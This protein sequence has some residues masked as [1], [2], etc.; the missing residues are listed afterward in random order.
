MILSKRTLHQNYPTTE[1]PRVRLVMTEISKKL[2]SRTEVSPG[3]PWGRHILFLGTG[4]LLF[5]SIVWFGGYQGIERLAHLR[6]GPLCLAF[7]ATIGVTVTSSIR[8]GM[9]INS[10]A[11]KRPA[12]WF[13]YYYY[14]IISR[15]LGHIVPKDIAD[16]GFRT[17]VASKFNGLGLS[18]AG[19][20]VIL[21]RVFDLLFTLLTLT[22]AVPYWLG[23]FT[24]VMGI[25]L[26]IV[27][28]SLSAVLLLLNQKFITCR[29][30]MLLNKGLR[31]LYRLPV[32][33]KREKVSVA[34][35]GLKKNVILRMYL[36]TAV[37]FGLLVL[38]LTMFAVALDACMSPFYILFG[39][40]LSQLSLL[41][42][43]TPGGLGIIEVGWFGI[44]KLGNVPTD[45][46]LIFVVGQRILTVMFVFLL[47]IL[48]HILFYSWWMLTSKAKLPGAN[49]GC[50]RK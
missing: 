13:E 14:L 30:D 6:L 8:W 27:L 42:A 41:F 2:E 24:P 15:A 21:D 5:G 34:F 22:S 31:L 17:L 46:A 37:K 48:C 10:L 7:L 49:H 47:A 3:E 1:T 43:F 9:I 39:I 23:W 11:M 26:I 28:T 12:T 45:Q 18:R 29:F 19:T 33:R 25:I 4:L 44:L 32:L 40:P 38:Q 36:L 50:W 20:S 35:Q 16:M